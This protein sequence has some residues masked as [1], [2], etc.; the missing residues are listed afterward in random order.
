MNIS[1]VHVALLVGAILLISGCKTKSWKSDQLV[2]L[3]R[4]ETGNST[5]PG[6]APIATTLTLN[7][8][9]RFV[10]SSLPPGFLQLDDVKPDHALSGIGTWSLTRSDGGEKYASY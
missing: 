2:G 1:R 10:A 5:A 9:G 6:N 3:W 7:H 8:D 4:P